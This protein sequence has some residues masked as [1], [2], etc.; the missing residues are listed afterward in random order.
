LFPIVFLFKGEILLKVLQIVP[1]VSKGDGIANVLV[2][3]FENLNKDNIVFDFLILNEASLHDKN[4]SFKDEITKLGGN[5]YYLG[6]PTRINEFSRK[7]RCFCSKHY[8]EYA[9]L[10]NNL[11]FLGFYFKNAISRLG[12]KK[13]IT[14][15][16]NP[17]YGDTMLT[18]LRNGLFYHLTGSP[19]GNVLFSSSRESGISLFSENRFNKPWY[20][21]NNAFKIENYKFNNVWRTR[22]RKKMGWEGKYVIGHVGRFSPQ[23]NQ[24]FLIK[25]FAKT[26]E[27]RKDA[28]LVLVGVGQDLTKIK[29]IVYKL[30]LQ[31]KVVFLGT[32]ND[33]NKLLQGIDLFAFP[34]KFEGLGLAAVEAQISGVPCIIS[35]KLPYEANIGHCK[36]LEVN[37]G[38]DAWSKE[39]INLKDS[40]RRLDG[41]ELAR[42]KGFDINCEARRLKEIYIHEI[43][44]N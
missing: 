13:V 6:N 25:V 3:Y 31:K 18:N 44:K 33:V 4:N 35:N 16:H 23:K 2:H 11:I 32:R 19:L 12:V 5:I 24:E 43:L 37:H 17:V 15:V 36:V 39:F 28:L 8:K 38:I 20:V 14:H 10:E 27:K 22:I 7:W 34:S 41:V 9:F 1:S 26:C 29:R 42:K 40:P 21:I 30:N